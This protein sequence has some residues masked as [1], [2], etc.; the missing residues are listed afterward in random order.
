MRLRQKWGSFPRRDG[1]IISDITR[2]L[3]DMHKPEANCE[4]I[5]EKM[6]L[7]I[8]DHDLQVLFVSTQQNNVKI[9][10]RYAIER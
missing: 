1:V 3:V 6:A 5:V 7:A 4:E 9:C 2:F 8:T 10:S